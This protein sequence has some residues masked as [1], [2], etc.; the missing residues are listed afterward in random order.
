MVAVPK[1]FGVG[2][3][4]TVRLLLAPANAMFAFGTRLVFDELPASVSTDAAVSASPIVNGTGP[5]TAFSLVVTLEMLEID[6][7]VLI[8]PVQQTF[9]DV[10][11]FSRQPCAMLPAS[12]NESS[13]V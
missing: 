10:V 13:R 12:C 5:A 8:T 7:A 4:V 6:G 9:D 1:R 2:V 3:S 11:M